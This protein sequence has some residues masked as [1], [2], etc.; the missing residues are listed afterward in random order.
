MRGG[1]QELRTGIASHF[2]PGL[3][4]LPHF[5]T[6][7]V[8]RPSDSQQSLTSTADLLLRA[9][10][11]AAAA[12]MDFELQRLHRRCHDLGKLLDESDI[13]LVDARSAVAASHRLSHF[14]THADPPT[15]AAVLGLSFPARPMYLA[16]TST[17]TS[18]LPVRTCRASPPPSPAQAVGTRA[19]T[20]AGELNAIIDGTSLTTVTAFAPGVIP[21]TGLPNISQHPKRITWCI[22][23]EVPHDARVMS[24]PVMSVSK[25]TAHAPKVTLTQT[26]WQKDT[27]FFEKQLQIWRA[28][29][30]ELTSHGVWPMLSAACT[31]TL[32]L[33]EGDGLMPVN[34]R[35]AFA[36]M[37]AHAQR[38]LSGLHQHSPMLLVMSETPPDA[39]LLYIDFSVYAD[40]ENLLTELVRKACSNELQRALFQ[41]GTAKSAYGKLACLTHLSLTAQFGYLAYRREVHSALHVKYATKLYSTFDSWLNHLCMRIAFFNTALSSSECCEG[42][43]FVDMVHALL[44]TSSLTKATIAQSFA[45]GP[46]NRLRLSGQFQEQ[47]YFDKLKEFLSTMNEELYGV[48]GVE[49]CVSES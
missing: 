19:W 31:G 12:N 8:F 4:A 16:P 14:A 22:S 15:R 25:L 6:M 7:G 23:G 18:A 41:H 21:R 17:P 35:A 27:N 29:Q 34:I 5:Q 36:D 42:A 20:T 1:Q 24:K 10:D 47:E 30:D 33:Y 3:A 11:D 2:S 32:R 38:P 43:D 13:A 49:P 26:V 28:F 45:R 37:C 48:H 39:A 40:V 46:D 44:D 9:R